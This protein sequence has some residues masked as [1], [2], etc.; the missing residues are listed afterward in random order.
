L[1]AL[2][3]IDQGHFLTASANLAFFV[4]MEEKRGTVLFRCP[5][6]PDRADGQSSTTTAGKW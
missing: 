3:N 5:D 4:G 1:L 2:W 6:P